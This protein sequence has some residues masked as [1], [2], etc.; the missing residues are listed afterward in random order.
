MDPMTM[1]ALASVA[2]PIIGGMFSGGGDKLKKVSNFDKGQQKFFDLYKQQAM[3]SQ[4]GMSNVM[5][6]LQSMLDPNSGFF[7][8][9]EN[10]MMNQFN[11][12][13]LPGIAKQFAGANAM[14]GG[15]MSSDFGQAMGG[16]ASGLQ[17]NLAAGKSSMIMQALQQLM[18]QYNQQAQ[19]VL[20]AKPFDY[21]NK[22]GG[23][24]FGGGFAQGASN[25]PWG[26]VMKM[27]SGGMGGMGGNKF[28]LTQGYDTMFRQQGVY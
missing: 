27:F 15:L 25:I 28:P 24:G 4:G 12:Q 11:E 18:Q 5:G 20:G 17:S 13:T 3:D 22:Q 8:N 9:F 19:T 6:L 16:A 26:D 1:A 10:Q 7:Q 2:A 21:I 23:G 14:G